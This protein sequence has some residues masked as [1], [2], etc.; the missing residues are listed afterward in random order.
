V[1][2]SEKT[3]TFTPAD[4]DL[5]ELCF[6]LRLPAAERERARVREALDALYPRQSPDAPWDL[7]TSGAS[8]LL[9]WA[10]AA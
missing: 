6:R 2:G 8:A 3:T 1:P 10:G 4:E 5:D 7:G 9:E